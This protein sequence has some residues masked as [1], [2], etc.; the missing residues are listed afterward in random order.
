MKESLLTILRDKHTGI[1]NFRNSAEKLALVLADEASQFLEKEKISINTPIEKTEGVKFK[2]NIVLV[3]ILRAALSLLPSFLKF[4]EDAKVG[5]LGLRRDEKT[6]VAQ[7]YYNN[8][9]KISNSDDV[10]ILDPMIAT[11][12]SGSKAIEILKAAGVRE[13]KII[14]VAVICA[15][16]GVEKIQKQYPDVRIIYVHKDKE[17]NKDKFIVPGLGDFGDRYFGTL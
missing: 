11:G 1:V 9:P 16:E 5:F 4:Y 2:N 17:L 3:P 8:L 13:N 7:V 15:S 10:I 14:F 6:A 12:G